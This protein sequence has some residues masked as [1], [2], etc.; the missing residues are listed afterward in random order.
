MWT[1]LTGLGSGHWLAQLKSEEENVD[2]VATSPKAALSR[3]NASACRA[4]GEIL[5]NYCSYALRSDAEL[6]CTLYVVLLL[7]GIAGRGV[8]QTLLHRSGSTSVCSGRGI[9]L[10]W[11]RHFPFPTMDN[12]NSRV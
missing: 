5:A 10:H 4:Q 9:A 3:S 6:L 11:S 12:P 2:L 8:R 1:R 7:V